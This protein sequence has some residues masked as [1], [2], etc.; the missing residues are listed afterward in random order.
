MAGDLV[1]LAD[2]FGELCDALDSTPR[3]SAPVQQVLGSQL[4]GL[5]EA[6]GLSP[7]D[8]LSALNLLD[9]NLGSE[10]AR[11]P[12]MMLFGRY[13]LAITVLQ[14]RRA[15]LSDV[16]VMLIPLARRLEELARMWASNQVD[17]DV[18]TELNDETRELAE[19]IRRHQNGSAA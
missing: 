7:F 16:H 19:E 9:P 5:L 1:R 8:P 18:L 6:A 4:G 10:Q 15:S 17:L 14:A 2:R 11:N 12:S 13:F 3:R